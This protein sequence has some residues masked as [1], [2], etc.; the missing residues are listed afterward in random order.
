MNMQP[1]NKVMTDKTAQSK[2][3]TVH[4]GNVFN[5]AKK[6]TVRVIGK[7]TPDMVRHHYTCMFLRNQ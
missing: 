5:M 4:S 6:D 1:F 7:M 2:D 3:T